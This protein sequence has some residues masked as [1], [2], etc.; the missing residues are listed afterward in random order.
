MN[1]LLKFKSADEVVTNY[2]DVKE[3]VAIAQTYA[4]KQGG[5]ATIEFN[6]KTA[7]AF[8]PDARFYII[9]TI[10]NA[11]GRAWFDDVSIREVLDP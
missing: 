8:E 3:N 9:L 10:D 11:T 1:A 2:K 5:L 6:A 7:E 4:D